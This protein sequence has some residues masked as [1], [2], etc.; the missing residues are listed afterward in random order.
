[1]TLPFVGNTASGTSN[2]YFGY[3]F[4]ASRFSENSKYVPSSLKTVVITG[5]SIIENNAFFGCTDLTRITILSGVTSIDDSAFRYCSSLTSITIPDSVTSI[6]MYAF[7]DC[8]SLTSIQFGGTT[9]QWNAISFGA[10]WNT[11]TGNYTVTC[12]DGTISKN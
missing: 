12:T 5:G 8:S 9:A 4:G 7:E 6:G 10:G 1:M 2:T 3:I 11:N